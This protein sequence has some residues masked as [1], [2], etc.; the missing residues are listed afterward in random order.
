MDG[1]LDNT[2]KSKSPPEAA[3]NLAPIVVPLMRG[4]QESAS[5]KK[6]D[7]SDEQV[8]KPLIVT[9]HEFGMDP[10]LFGKGGQLQL[11]QAK[12]W[13]QEQAHN[14]LVIPPLFPNTAAQLLE[15]PQVIEP[16]R[17]NTL[18]IPRLIGSDQLPESA[19]KK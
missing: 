12:E 19:G 17:A 13:E 15:I 5:G 9:Q 14:V 3:E 8:G 16:K 11:Q 4:R 2:S 6:P 7:P 18:V 1:L 10:A